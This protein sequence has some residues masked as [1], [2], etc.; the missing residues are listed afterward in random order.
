MGRGVSVM[1][2]Q[3]RGKEGGKGGVMGLQRRRKDGGR[4]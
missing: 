3:R 1:E 2:L 4:V